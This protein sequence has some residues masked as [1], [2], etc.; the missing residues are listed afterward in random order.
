MTDLSPN[1]ARSIVINNVPLGARGA[2]SLTSQD[3][4]VNSGY[5]LEALRYVQIDTISVIQRAHN[6]VLSLRVPGYQES[7][8]DDLQGVSDSGSRRI[9]EYW[10]HAAAYLPIRDLPVAVARMRRMRREGFSWF[11]EHPHISREVLKAI[12][13]EGPLRAADFTDRPR[14]GEAGWWNWKPAKIALEHLFHQGHLAVVHRRGFQKVYDLSER[15][16]PGVEDLPDPSE[17]MLAEYLIDSTLDN[18][19]I[20]RQADM[21]RQ[22]PDGKKALAGVLAEQT[23]KGILQEISINGK[24]GWY[25]R[26]EQLNTGSPVGSGGPVGSVGSVA[27]PG[28]LLCNPFDNLVINRSWMAAMF[29]YDYTIEC[30][31]PEAKR[32][33]GYYALPILWIPE[34]NQ[35]TQQIRFIG[36]VDCKAHRKEQRLEVLSLIQDEEWSASFHEPFTQE[37][38]VLAQYNH[39]TKVDW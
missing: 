33:R 36:T 8:L 10:F 26:S 28:L 35:G 2:I 9:F 13:A 6:H 25:I 4:V 37:L 16:L 5:I 15:V 39:C 22:R 14:N 1:E 12:E 24:S 21:M 32:Q 11:K 30:Y 27:P 38:N 29:G 23:T 20:A 31:V 19:V 34:P 18:L 7:M 17:Q 3:P